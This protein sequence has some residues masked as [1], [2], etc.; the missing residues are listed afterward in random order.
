MSRLPAELTDADRV[1]LGEYHL[2]TLTTLRPDG[3]PHT[4]PVGVT[5]DG[6]TARVITRAASAKARHAALPGAR[7]S[8]CSVDGGRWLTLEGP[9]TVSTDPTEIA[10]A[11]ELYA[12]RYRPP[13]ESP[14]RVALLITVDRVLG[15]T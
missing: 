9:V 15:R 10:L 11:V 1:F 14:T 12:Q 4:V 3:S 8:A 6:T 13:S 2:A 5:F 7:A